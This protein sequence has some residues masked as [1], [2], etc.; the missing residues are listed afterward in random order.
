MVAPPQVSNPLNPISS[1]IGAA[2]SICAV[3]MRVAAINWC[4]SRKTVLLNKTDFII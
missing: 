4:P 1:R 3:V 2:G